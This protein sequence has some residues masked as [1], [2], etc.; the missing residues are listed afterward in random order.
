MIRE[1]D[2]SKKVNDLIL[3]KRRNFEKNSEVY[4]TGQ[5][6]E[7]TRRI[8]YRTTN[9]VRDF[10]TRIDE[11]TIKSIKNKWVD[12]FSSIQGVYVLDSHVDV[13]DCNYNLAGRIDMVV[14]Y[15]GKTIA[16]FVDPVDSSY[17]N[18]IGLGIKSVKRKDIVRFVTNMWMGEVSV[19]LIIFEDISTNKFVIKEL[20]PTNKIIEGVKRKCKRINEFILLSKTPDRDYKDSSSVECSHCE[21]F[22][23]CWNK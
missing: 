15:D 4:L 19:G 21:F 2:L 20:F 11:F 23:K 8:F 10:E 5:I 16:V 1:S 12:I 7:C 18:E 22:N 3:N 6:T 14:R 17:F 9:C 13:S